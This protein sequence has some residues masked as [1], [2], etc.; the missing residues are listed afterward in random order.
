MSENSTQ[1]TVRTILLADDNADIRQ[2]ISELL[3]SYGHQ[4][5]CAENGHDAVAL[6]EK[7]NTQIDLLILDV[8]MPR[9]NGIDA[10]HE[11]N[12]IR[13]GTKAIF[14]GGY[15][16]D[17]FH[18]FK[19]DVVYLEKPLDLTKLISAINQYLDCPD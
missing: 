7:H 3:S 5:I 8:M 15:S 12:L 9:K 18:K 17:M 14:M 2:S 6:F 11:I 19:S 10:Y 1:K 4:V 16:T 13:P